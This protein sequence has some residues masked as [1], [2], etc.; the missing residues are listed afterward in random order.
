MK[1]IKLSQS[2]TLSRKVDS[3]VGW[4]DKTVYEPVYINA[5]HIESFAYAGIT[6]IKMTSGEQIKVSESPEE[7]LKLLQDEV[8]ITLPELPKLGSNEEWYQGYAA[9]AESMR[10]ECRDRIV[11]RGVLARNPS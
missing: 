7:I 3:I 1:I 10:N 5:N 2:C 9:G 4:E 11:K 8:V 6:Y